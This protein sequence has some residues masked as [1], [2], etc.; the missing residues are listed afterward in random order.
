MPQVPA[1]ES[2]LHTLA[3][4]TMARAMETVPAYAELLLP[5]VRDRVGGD[6]VIK[7]FSDQR[8]EELSKRKSAQPAPK[9]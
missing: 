5:V 1:P 3:G 4:S 2:A 8:I 7:T 6:S 9:P